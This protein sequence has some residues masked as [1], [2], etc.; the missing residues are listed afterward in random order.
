MEFL[1]NLKA[2]FAKKRVHDEEKPAHPM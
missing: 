2:R 1:K